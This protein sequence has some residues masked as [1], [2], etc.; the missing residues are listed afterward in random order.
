MQPKLTPQTPVGRGEALP[1]YR[2]GS[3]VE[4][5]P[6]PRPLVDEGKQTHRRRWEHDAFGIP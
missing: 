1:L 3:T 5:V 6:K 2:G 4:G